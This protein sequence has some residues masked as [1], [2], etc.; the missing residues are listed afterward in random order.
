MKCWMSIGP[1]MENSYVSRTFINTR[2]NNLYI[3]GFNNNLIIK[4]V[5]VLCNEL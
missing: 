4:I 5:D 1:C 3:E 2:T